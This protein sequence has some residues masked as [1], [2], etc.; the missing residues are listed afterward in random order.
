MPHPGKR[1][2][3]L[4]V[5][6]F[7][8]FTFLSSTQFSLPAYAGKASNG[9]YTGYFM[10]HPSMAGKKTNGNYTLYDVSDPVS[11][12]VSNGNYTA[13]LGMV[14]IWAGLLGGGTPIEPVTYDISNLKIFRKDDAK[15]SDIWIAFTTLSD[16]ANIAL[17][18]KESEINDSNTPWNIITLPAAD[19]SIRKATTQDL[20]LPQLANYA[21]DPTISAN[22]WL[23]INN[24][25]VGNLTPR[26]KYYR[27]TTNVTQATD[28]KKCMVGRITIKT[29]PPQNLLIFGYPFASPI[30]Q[31]DSMDEIIG[32]QLYQG[33]SNVADQIYTIDYSSGAFI[34]SYLNKT[35][36]WQ[37]SSYVGVEQ[38]KG[39][40]LIRGKGTKNE[41]ITIVG[42]VPS[43]DKSTTILVKNLNLITTPYPN[44]YS[45][46]EPYP[47]GIANLIAKL[48]GG[49]SGTADQIYGHSGPDKIGPFEGS[50]INP[51]KKLEG[52]LVNLQKALFPDQAYLVFNKNLPAT[53]TL[54]GFDFEY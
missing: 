20:A 7:F 9:N 4:L 25:Q 17:S 44:R 28:Y 16:Q 23:I 1:V 54:E 12:K 2:F 11:G 41:N 45:L 10:V 39:Y 53:A 26:Q 51:Q 37:S 24:K 8:L 27:V 13:Y 5:F 43:D 46:V 47:N 48:D 18:I 50:F 36:K 32:A 29:P 6:I 42:K 31:K 14:G 33:D 49:T 19:Y 38:G 15:D 34:G 3:S 30:N 40:L 52:N 22:T 21:N 35:G